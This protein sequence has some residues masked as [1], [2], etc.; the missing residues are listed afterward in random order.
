MIELGTPEETVESATAELAAAQRL[1]DQPVGAV[2]EPAL[3]ALL[4]GKAAQAHERGVEFVV[5][6]DSAVRRGVA[7]P[8]D[9]VTV[10]GNLVDNAI[11]AALAGTPPRRVTVTARE[12][13]DALVLRVADTGDG[14]PESSV[15]DAFRRGWTTKPAARLHGRGLGLALVGQITERHG[16]T[17]EVGHEGGAVFTVRLPT[18]V[19]AR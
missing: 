18:A 10:V 1:T 7:E 11:D 13:G 6:P 15:R 17:V 9:L 16:G 12:D 4:L 3:A 14:L 5:T 8:R 2:G 19:T